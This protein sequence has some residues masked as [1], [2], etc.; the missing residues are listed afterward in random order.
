MSAR[1][2]TRSMASRFESGSSIRYTLGSRT[3]ARPIATRCRWPPES[4]PGLRSRY[5]VSP[6]S[7]ATPPTRRSRSDLRTCDTRRG[8][9]MFA[10]G[11]RERRLALRAHHAAENDVCALAAQ[12]GA[13]DGDAHEVD[14][15]PRDARDDPCRHAILDRGR[16]DDGRQLEQAAHRDPSVVERLRELGGAGEAERGGDDLL[17]QGLRPAAI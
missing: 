14:D 6:S 4:W 16:E 12:V 15:P 3:I 9:A 7:S 13:V 2:C 8:K 5:S 10:A 11:G 1:I 17:E